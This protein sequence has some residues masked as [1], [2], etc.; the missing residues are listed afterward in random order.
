MSLGSQLSFDISD[1]SLVLRSDC[2]KC[3]D[4]LQRLTGVSSSASVRPGHQILPLEVLADCKGISFVE[5]RPCFANITDVGFGLTLGYNEVHTIVCHGTKA[6]I[7]RMKRNEPTI[8]FGGALI[9]GKN[10]AISTSLEE[11]LSSMPFSLAD[12]VLV[13]LSLKGGAVILHKKKNQAVDL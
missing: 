7:D 5:T 9:A 8:N 4:V 10:S 12:G 1:P 11:G 2:A 3:C 6:A 13:D